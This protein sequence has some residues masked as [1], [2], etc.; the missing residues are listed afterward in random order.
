MASLGLRFMSE[1]EPRLQVTECTSPDEKTVALDAFVLAMG[2]EDRAFHVLS[3]CKFN[4]T[5]KCILIRYKN[6]VAGNR[7]VYEKYVNEIGLRFKPENLIVV[8]LVSEN[9]DAFLHDLKIAISKLE[10]EVRHF[11]I[12]I[13]GMT[14][15]SICITMKCVRESRPFQKQTVFY[16]SAKEYM[17]SHQEYEEL[18]TKL[19]VEKLGEEI[20][21][22]PKSMAL[23]M[24]DNL[25]L[26]A[27]AG[28][29]SGDGKPC[30]ALFAGYEVHRSSGTIDATN[31]SLLLLLY[32]DP[33]DAAL[34]WRLDLSKSLH[35]KF[36]KGRRC[37]SEVVST[38]HIQESIDLLEKY[39][40]YLID[41]HDLIIA[42]ICSKMHTLAAFLFWER[43]G[44][45][46]LTFPLP[47]GY[48]PEHKPVGVGA[49]YYVELYEPRM[50]FRNSSLPE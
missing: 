43:Y 22:L 14:S 28:H 31:P 50:F 25:V 21:Y 24:S 13:S 30:L 40:N 6:D 3:K 29:R 46:Q 18:L 32:G 39:Y 37:A 38:L 1:I 33:G 36:E 2:F 44:E 7:S 4:D 42:P 16:T 49:S 15:Y 17:P 5:A 26:D 45:V 8:D 27:F 48:N 12:D 19:G 11:G 47:I 9:V 10:A 23:E 35:A 34:K 20:D 41:D